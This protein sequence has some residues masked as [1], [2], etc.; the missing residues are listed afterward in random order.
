M[1][2]SSICFSHWSNAE[3]ILQT[4]TIEEGKVTV[5]VRNTG[6]AKN[7][8]SVCSDPSQGVLWLRFRRSD[9]TGILRPAGSDEEGF[10]THSWNRSDARAMSPAKWIF[11]KDETKQFSMLLPV[12]IPKKSLFQISLIF[13][14]DKN[15]EN[16]TAIL[17]TF[18]ELDCKDDLLVFRY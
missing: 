4:A 3:F 7:V 16:R 5:A 10:W 14:T 6:P 17:S 1:A 18:N 9:D 2:Y 15:L 13:S 12:D 11:Q 8:Y